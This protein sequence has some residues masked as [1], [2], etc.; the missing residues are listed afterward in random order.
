MAHAIVVLSSVQSECQENSL[1]YTIDLLITMGWDYLT[2]TATTGPVVYSQGDMWTCRAMVKIVPAGDN[3]WLVYQTFLEVLPADI[4][5]ESW[6]NGLRSEDFAY[7]YV[8][9]LKG[10]LTCREILRHGPPALLPHRRKVCCGSLSPLNINRF[11]RVWSIGN[12]TNLYATEA[13]QIY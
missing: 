10:Y 7:Q 8:K 4:S 12:H 1:K 6:R 2:T 13:T 11:G 3:P 5:G 9:Y